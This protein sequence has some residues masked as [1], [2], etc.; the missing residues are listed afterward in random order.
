MGRTCQDGSCF[1]ARSHDGGLPTI[2][3]V[4]AHS[5]PL[6]GKPGIAE[7]LKQNLIKRFPGIRVVGTYTPPFRSL[8]ATEKAELQG[9]LSGLDP[10]V[11]WVGLSTPKQ[12]EFM[13]ENLGSL[14]CK[15][16][17]GVGAAFDIHTGHVKDAPQWIKILGLQW[18][19]RLCQEPGRLWKRYLVNNSGFL[20][21]TFLQFTGIKRYQLASNSFSSE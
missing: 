18:L 16:M 12:E 15:I 8:L 19:H 9:E 5:L 13:A 14:N 21:R 20:V 17:I 6:W 7:E 4:G 2:R 11:I 10:D 3:E 1:R